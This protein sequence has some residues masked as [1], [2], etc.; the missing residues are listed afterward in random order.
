MLDWIF[1][2]HDYNIIIMHAFLVV[3]TIS[4]CMAFKLNCIMQ[5]TIIICARS[6]YNSTCC[7][8]IMTTDDLDLQPDWLTQNQDCLLSTTIKK[9]SKVSRDPYHHIMAGSGDEPI[10]TIPQE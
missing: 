1:A 6:G 9:N 8:D 5:S 7:Y 4:G 10:Q 3:L 2:I